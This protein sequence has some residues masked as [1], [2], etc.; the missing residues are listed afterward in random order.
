MYWKDYF[1]TTLI[2]LNEKLRDAAQAYL[3]A[4][5]PRGEV[6]VFVHV[7][8]GDYLGFTAYGLGDLELSVDF[9]RRAIS[10]VKQKFGNIHLVF[11]TDDA[12]WVAEHFSDAA[13]KSIASF[14]PEMDFAIM[15]ECRGGVVS[16]STFSLAAAFMMSNPDLVVGPEYWFGFRVSSWYP[17]E[18]RCPHEKLLYLSVNA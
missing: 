18:I 5:C 8:R 17:P 2:E 9:Y 16:N 7:R 13:I 3:K 12:L 10:L 11:V 14:S 6:P 4:Q 15:T 1:P